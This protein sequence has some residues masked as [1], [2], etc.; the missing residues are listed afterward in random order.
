MRLPFV[1]RYEARQYRRAFQDTKAFFGWNTQTL[2]FVGLT[3]PGWP[4]LWW[5]GG[6]E[7]VV[8]EFAGPLVR[9]GLF[10]FGKW[11]VGLFI[12]PPLWKVG[13]RDNGREI[14]EDISRAY[15]FS[16]LWGLE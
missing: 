3:I 7:L 6:Q 2:V 12:D 14:L 9:F 8:E 4:L 15:R 1:I 10:R 5:V 11:L 16:L 13:C